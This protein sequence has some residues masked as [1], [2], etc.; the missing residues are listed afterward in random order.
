[1]SA[2]DRSN[3]PGEALAT[4]DGGKTRAARRGLGM[5]R[6][7]AAVFLALSPVAAGCTPAEIEQSIELLTVSFEEGGLESGLST[8]AIIGQQAVLVVGMRLG[9]LTP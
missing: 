7:T 2:I 1:M 9:S 8:A 4:I 3:G 5:R 6:F